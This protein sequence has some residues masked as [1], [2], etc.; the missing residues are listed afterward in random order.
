MNPGLD[1][2]KELCGR[3]LIDRF[4]LDATHLPI[5]LCANGELLCDPDEAE[6]AIGDVRSGSAKRVAAAVGEGAQ[7]IA[8]LHTHLARGRMTT[9]MPAA[10]ERP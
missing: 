9:A 8:A 10:L 3:T 6:F 7:L 5:V 1:P 2:H 4:A